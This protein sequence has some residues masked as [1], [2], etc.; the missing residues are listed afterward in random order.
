MPL[1]IRQ[2]RQQR[3]IT[4]PM[5]KRGM[6]LV[7]LPQMMNL[8]WALEITNYIPRSFGI[9]KRKGLKRIFNRTGATGLK[10]LREFR[11][12]VWIFAHGTKLEI[13]DESTDTFTT[14]KDDF[15]G[16]QYSGD[17]YG[18]YF[19]VG[20]GVAKGGRVSMT[21]PYDGQ[22][23][24]FTVGLKVTGADSGA[25]AIILEDSDSGATG[26]LTLGSIQGTFLNDEAITDT[27]TGA[28]VVNGTLT[29]TYTT[30]TNAPVWVGISIIGPR[31][32][33]WYADTVQYSEVDDGTTNPPFTVW[34]DTTAADAGGKASYRNA[35][36]VRSVAQLGPYTVVFSDKGFYAF[37]IQVLDSAGTLKKVE[38]VQNYTEDFG[39]ATGAISTPIGIF[40]VNEQGL[41]QMVQVGDT[42]VPMSRQQVLSSKP[43]GSKYFEGVD[44][45]TVDLVYSMKEQAVLATVAKNS[46]T[47]NLVIGYKMDDATGMFQIQNWNISVFAK[48]DQEIYGASSIDGRMFKLFSGDTDDGLKIGTVYDQEIPMG[49][50]F[51]ANSLEG[52]YCAG[53]LTPDDPVNVSF[54]IFDLKG[55]FKTNKTVLQMNAGDILS[56]AEGWG[57]AIWGASV[58][59]GMKMS[60]SGLLE[61]FAGGSPRISNFQRLRIK[62]TNASKARHIVSWFSVKT[63]KKSPIKRRNMTLIS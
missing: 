29:Y 12:G 48:S 57:E 2:P 3:Y 51:H 28:A 43:L 54:S 38:Y 15:A 32:F 40:Y 13:Y 47:N 25:T 5:A 56:G 31:A 62:I 45:T 8:D 63:T 17:K 55:R 36:D 26:V 58:W 41:W 18:D 46:E 1:Q 61:T 27:S 33:A 22:T 52:L 6:N 11:P 30:I 50:L 60:G 53:F 4:S 23:A 49:T 7:D 42:D 14:I 39:G 37:I 21:L 34:S 44:Q 9:E 59:G 35:G 24:N 20:D 19:F 16:T 10:L